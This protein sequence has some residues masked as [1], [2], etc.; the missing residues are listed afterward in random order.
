MS[1]DII[2]KIKL[3][4]A[5]EPDAAFRE[6]NRRVLMMQIKNTLDVEAETSN[7]LFE[8]FLETFKVFFPWQIFK[9]ALRPVLAVFLIFGLVLGSG[10]SVSAA[11]ASLPGDVFYPLKLATEKIQVALTFREEE[12]T[13]MHVELAGKRIG[14]VSK[15]KDGA[16]SP[17]A[18]SKKI[19][20]AVGKFKEE[21]ENVKTKLETLDKK[22]ESQKVVEVARVVDTK[23]NEYQNTL[24]KTN[25]DLEASVKE[26]VAVKVN[27]G[28]DSAEKTGDK[29]LA[30]IVDKQRQGGVDLSEEEV[31][32]RL[33]N[34]IETVENKVVKVEKQIEALNSAAPPMP[35]VSS[36]PTTPAPAPET[37]QT[38]VQMQETTNQAKEV[39]NQA[40]ELLNQKENQ[41]DLGAVLDKVIESK[42]LVNQAGQKAT[43]A[44]AAAPSPEA[45][46]SDTNANV[47]ADANANT[48]VNANVNAD[49]NSN[50]NA[51]VN[52]NS[53]TNVNINV[54]INA[55]AETNKTTDSSIVNTN[56]N[57]AIK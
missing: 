28:L 51:D 30:V 8:T 39:L 36:N 19:N 47:N 13:E 41:K 38:T 27:E 55:S 2:K 21:M 46:A 42:E 7:T 1:R 32:E 54:N 56:T 34:K 10:L 37:E 49:T 15:I 23:S 25:D 4:R 5:V 44:T 14:E 57:T 52:V 35:E 29:A 53:D 40:K 12:K 43:E 6:S 3:L 45:N 22:V 31:V 17:A 33:G 18:K 26:S 9:T 20:I 11:E 16:D 48:N 24:Q 50:I